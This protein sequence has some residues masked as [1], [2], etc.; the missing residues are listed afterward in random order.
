M[1]IEVDINEGKREET[2]ESLGRDEPED[3]NGTVNSLVTE[4]FSG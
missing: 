1:S 2:G 4:C 3:K